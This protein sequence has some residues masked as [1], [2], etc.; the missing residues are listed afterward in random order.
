MHIKE[1]KTAIKIGDFVLKQSHRN[2]INLKYLPNLSRQILTDNLARIYL[3]VQDGIIKKIGG[4]TSK[5]GIKATMSFYTS[6]MTGSPGVPRFII[7]LLVFKALKSGSKIELFMITSPKTL[8]TV[9]GLFGSKKVEIASFKEMED[10]CKAD[11]FLKEN[12]YPDWNFQENHQPYPAVLAKKHVLYH[13]N[14][15]GKKTIKNQKKT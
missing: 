8:A 9:N 2:K 5:G 1:V 11:Y 7:H 10:L 13:Q 12:K 14:R 4:S 3:F 6:A 15:L